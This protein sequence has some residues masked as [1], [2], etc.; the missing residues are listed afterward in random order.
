V[1]GV[2]ATLAA[3]ASAELTLTYTRQGSADPQ[4][5]KLRLDYTDA[6]AVLSL[7]NSDDTGAGP[8]VTCAKG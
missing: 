3:P 7:R 8:T 6:K 5:T 1:T 4:T 2:P